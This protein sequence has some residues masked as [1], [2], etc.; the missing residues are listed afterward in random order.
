MKSRLPCHFRY[1]IEVSFQ[2]LFRPCDAYRIQI[3]KNRLAGPFS[4]LAVQMIKM[5]VEAFLQEFP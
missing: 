3:D 4:E 2:K 5:V 1:R